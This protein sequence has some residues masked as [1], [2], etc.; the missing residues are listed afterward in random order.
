MV[1]I[2]GAKLVVAALDRTTKVVPRRIPVTG[3]PRRIIFS[4]Q[5]DML[6][7]V[8]TTSENK[9]PRQRS[10]PGVRSRP[11]LLLR[12]CIEFINPDQQMIKTEEEEPQLLGP[13]KYIVP[14]G[15]V[16]ERVL[17][18]IDWS[19]SEGVK[20]YHFIVVCTSIKHP[21]GLQDT[22]RIAF[23][24][25]RRNNQGGLEVAQKYQMGIPCDR[26][27]YSVASLGSSSLVYC[28]GTELIIQSLSLSDRRWHR[29]CDH[30][31]RSPAIHLNVNHPFIYAT[32]ASDSVEV[33]RFEDNTL[34]PQFRYESLSR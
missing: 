8:V 14:A 25:A 20:T 5:L 15:R 23:F 3:T 4:K 26:P 12:D 17:G 10:S 7:V 22:G 28:S 18:I 24:N 11:R 31:L 19:P 16:G 21:G 29:V 9:P 34:S 13:P 32:T 1:L 2:L 33:L 6:V 30:Y 27:A